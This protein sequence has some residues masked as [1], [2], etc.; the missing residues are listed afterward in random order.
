MYQNSS[1][2]TNHSYPNISVGERQL[3]DAWVSI[4]ESGPFQT[5]YNQI[6]SN[7]SANGGFTSELGQNGST[8]EYDA[9]F[10]FNYLASCSDA[11]DFSSSGCDY[12]TRW[13]VDLGT[14]SAAGPVTIAET[15]L[16]SSPGT[17]ATAPSKGAGAGVPPILGLSSYEGYAVLVAIAVA[18]GSAFA[19][20]LRRSPGRSS[21]AKAASPTVPPTAHEVRRPPPEGT[22]L[23]LVRLDPPRIPTSEDPLGDVY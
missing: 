17:N 15:P 16:G 23:P 19:V 10:G 21:K 22:N 5:L 20:G 8:G 6:A 4:C 2:S 7:P 14:G 12:L 18:V 1:G 13:F 11:M 3:H 9:V